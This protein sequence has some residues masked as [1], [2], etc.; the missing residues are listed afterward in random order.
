MKLFTYFSTTQKTKATETRV[1]E[2]SDLIA[3]LKAEIE[4]MKKEANDSREVNSVL[5]N[6]FSMTFI[7]LRF[8]KQI[9]C[10]SAMHD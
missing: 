10:E 4:R 1:Q 6:T 9:A 3:Q 5:L 2:Q 8:S 7:R